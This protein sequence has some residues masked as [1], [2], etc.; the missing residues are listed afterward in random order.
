MAKST[1]TTRIVEYPEYPVKRAA[2][3]F[4]NARILLP[5]EKPESDG[6]RIIVNVSS[7]DLIGS[8]LASNPIND[9]ITASVTGVDTMDSGKDKVK[10]PDIIEPAGGPRRP[11]SI[12]GAA[13]EDAIIARPT[14]A[15]CT[16]RIRYATASAATGTNT[17][18]A[19]D[20]IRS[21]SRPLKNLRCP[22]TMLSPE[23]NI[24]PM[25]AIEVPI[26]NSNTINCP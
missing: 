9:D 14:A 24:S 26:F 4:R 19:K 15:G 2:D 20:C 3:S 23:Q 8:I 21:E 22:G 17:R 10:A 11:V 16:G 1:K 25:T 18:T 12:S 5:D 13:G 7:G 6:R